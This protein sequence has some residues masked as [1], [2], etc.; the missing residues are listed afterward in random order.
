MINKARQNKK[1][2]TLIELLVV[3]L[4]I[5][6]LSTIVFY[7]VRTTRRNA[8]EGRIQQELIQIRTALELYYAKYGVYPEPK[9]NYQSFEC[10]KDVRDSN[11]Q[12]LQVLV[13]EKF[14]SKNPRFPLKGDL[15]GSNTGYCY[16]R[17]TQYGGYLFM[18]IS[19]KP[20]VCKPDGKTSIS[21]ARSCFST[22]NSTI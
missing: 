20:A 16:Q 5:S 14:L 19:T 2:F 7:V 17:N 22:I 18:Y 1:G 13:D 15:G 11:N 3:I 9:I 10:Y 6:L 8:D 12:F 4:I 21:S